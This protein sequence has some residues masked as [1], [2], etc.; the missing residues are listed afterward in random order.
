MNISYNFYY[1][2]PFLYKTKIDKIIL[3]EIKK[4]C[5]KKIDTR[6]TLAGHLK[7]E[8][9]VDKI[10]FFNILHVYF[11]HYVMEAKKFYGN[12][13]M[14]FNLEI[15]SSWVNYMKQNEYNPVHIHNGDLSCVLYL[16]IPEKL[17]KEKNEHVANSAP[18]GSICFLYGECRSL[19]INYQYF[20]PEEGDF[21]IFPAN[22]NHMV[23]PYKS[24]CERISLSA[25]LNL[26]N[27][28][29]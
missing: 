6:R 22:L 10:K 23:I 7:E 19:N 12:V 26:I 17:K 11:N 16:Q 14:N 28:T 5:N 20:F 1:W 25:N 29:K 24:K 4:L 3:K 9:K 8:Y 27:E 21:F 15:I 13:N 2:G 18:P